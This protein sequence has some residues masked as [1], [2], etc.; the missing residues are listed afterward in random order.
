[1]PGILGILSKRPLGDGEA[2][3]Q[4]MLGSMLH[5][6]SYISATYLDHHRGIYLGCIALDSA[7]KGWVLPAGE[8][9]GG[10]AAMLAGEC[11]LDESLLSGLPVAA[12]ALSLGNIRHVLAAYEEMGDAVFPSING[13]FAGV[14]VDRRQGRVLLFNDR[15][16]M[17]KVYY[18]ESADAVYFASEAKAILRVVPATR[19]ID[20]EA[21]GEYLNYDC[22]LHNRSFFKGINLLPG[23]SKWVF[24]DGTFD[25]GSYFSPHDWE[26]QEPLDRKTFLKLACSTFDAIVPR[27]FTGGPV[28]MALTG[29]LDTRSVL[30]ARRPGPGE[31][32]CYTFAGMYRESLD[33]KVA[34]K[35]ATTCGQSHACIRLGPEFLR[36]Y[37][38]HV[39]RA[40][41][42]TDGLANAT[43]ADELYLNSL[44]RNI[45]PVKMTGKFGSQVLRSVTGLRAR[46]PASG[47][48]ARDFFP[49]MQQ[50]RDTFSRIR[51][52]H[53]L[54]FFLFHECPW[55]WS[56]FT[57][58]EQSQLTVRS[59][60]LDND[61]VR[62]L[63]Q[64]PPELLEGY[65]FHENIMRRTTP[66]LLEIRTD[67]GMYGSSPPLLNGLL[68]NW[69]RMQGTADKLYTW[70]RIPYN[71][72]DWVARADS[73]L[74]K[75]LHLD[76]LIRGRS[77][78]RHYRPWFRDELSGYVRDV[79]LDQRTLERP[80]WNAEFVPSIV[81]DHQRGWKNYFLEIRKILTVE[82]I[83][84]TLVEN[85][86]QE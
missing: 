34:R 71:L 77:F 72:T 10:S 22:V 38:E 20:P 26:Q 43:M 6:P 53:A 35:V 21:M 28:A 2:R 70:D 33:V 47:L 12:K 81:R 55:Y 36:A 67:K 31:L 59:P 74:L 68:K 62:T 37:P 85:A 51:T 52:G 7:V 57:V 18:H 39:E 83:H 32:P 66:K 19:A 79:L 78:F 64:S 3:L 4:K 46:Y 16:G 80:Y 75:P 86:A 76:A 17:Q 42:M 25:K 56:A 69:Y 24:A 61:F 48:I 73:C 82:L 60:Y 50:A 14:I 15:F 5:S 65:I 45:A 58:A 1:M 54:S 9:T 84:R 41:Y 30:A 8:D 11:C 49:I 44:A 13:W 40:V 63:Y 29:G 27:Y 23:G